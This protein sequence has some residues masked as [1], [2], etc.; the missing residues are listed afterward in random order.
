MI[1]LLMCFANLRFHWKHSCSGQSRFDLRGASQPRFLPE[2]L[3]GPNG[4]SFCSGKVETASMGW[5]EGSSE[6]AL[7]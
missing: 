1:H 4:S 6:I 2:L 3:E 5:N 7:N